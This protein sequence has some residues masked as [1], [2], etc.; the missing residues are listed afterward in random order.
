MTSNGI[1]DGPIG[2]RYRLLAAKV[3]GL[4]G[5]AKSAEART[6]LLRIAPLYETLA[7][8]MRDLLYELPQRGA[9][10]GE[11]PIE[12]GGDHS[13]DQLVPNEIALRGE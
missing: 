5:K 8:C 4:V 13:V 9:R 11:G 2:Q 3:R 1:P 6:E 10:R 7:D 12:A